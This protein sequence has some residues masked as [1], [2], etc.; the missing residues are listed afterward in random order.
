M[1]AK[2]AR[3]YD[4]VKTYRKLRD[5][6][7]A[8]L[9][10][11]DLQAAP[12]GETEPLGVLCRKLGETQKGYIESFRSFKFAFTYE[13]EDPLFES[14]IE[15]IRAWYQQLD[16]ELEAVLESLSDSDADERLIYRTEELSCRL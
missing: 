13:E 6:L 2:L 10:D 1:N 7:T 15:S 11:Q 9:T 5:N 12:G 8:I 14:S 16:E 3:Q 4:I